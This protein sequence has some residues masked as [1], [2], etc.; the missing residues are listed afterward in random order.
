[1]DGVGIHSWADGRKY[2]GSFVA[3]LRH[4]HGIYTWPDGAK[5]DGDY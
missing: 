4:G 1:M 3:N 2:E 5:Y